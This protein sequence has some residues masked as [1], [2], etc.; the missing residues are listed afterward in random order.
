MARHCH[1]IRQKYELVCSRSA[2]P[3]HIHVGLNLMTTAPKREEMSEKTPAIPNQ[4]VQAPA[5]DEIDLR[6]S[7]NLSESGFSLYLQTSFEKK[8][9]LKD[10]ASIPNA[11]LCKKINI[12][13]LC[14][15]NFTNTKEQE[16]ILL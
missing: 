16:T 14:K 1:K 6:A 7:I 4:W 8:T 12:F 13:V 9:T 2:D 15:Y 5:S 11:I 3:L 10:A